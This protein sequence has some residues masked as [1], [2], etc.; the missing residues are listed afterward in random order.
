[1]KQIRILLAGMPALLLDILHHVVV[2]EADMAVVG[3]IENG[4]LLAAM[5][6]SRPNVLVI[7]QKA[8]NERQK[9]E[10]LLWRHPRLR[11]LTIATDGKSGALY[12][13]HPQRTSIGSLSADALRKAI[14]GRRRPRSGGTAAKSTRAYRRGSHRNWKA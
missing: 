11:L 12:K 13:L 10:P 1:L 14:R 8:K 7:G 2:S 6:Q 4:D 3:Q 9:Y 5:R